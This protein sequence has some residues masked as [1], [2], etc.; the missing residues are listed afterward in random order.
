MSFFEFLKNKT[1]TNPFKGFFKKN[2]LRPPGAVE[3]KQFMELCIRCARCIEVC[4]YESI[5]R[6]DLYDKLQIGTPYVYVVEKA[7]YLCMKCP[8]VCPT[9]ALDPKMIYPEKVEMGK[10]IIHQDICLNYLYYK[11][12]KPEF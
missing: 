7:C 3:E 5:K 2:R 8:P 4:P 11:E 6:A 10:A 9:G 1:K 12:E